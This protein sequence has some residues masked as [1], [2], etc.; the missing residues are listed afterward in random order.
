MRASLL[1]RLIATAALATLAACASRPVATTAELTPAP[2]PVLASVFARNFGAYDAGVFAVLD[3]GKAIWLTNVPAGATRTI[4]VTAQDLQVSGLVL[5][6][7]AIGSGHTWTSTPTLIDGLGTGV[8]DVTS[9][10]IGNPAGTLLR[11]VPTQVL[12]AE[13]R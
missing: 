7:Q 13:M 2:S 1:T 11:V 6:V 12:H 10:R 3:N 8:L 4:P 5:R 9:D